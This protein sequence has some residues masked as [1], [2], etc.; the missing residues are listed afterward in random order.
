[1]A[2]LKS[3][4]QEA[5]A[6]HYVL[7]GNASEAYRKAYSTKT[8][9]SQ[10][11]NVNAATLLKNTNVAPRVNELQHKASEAADKSFG[12]DAEWMLGR[13]KSIDELDIADLLDDD[14]TPLPVKQWPKVWRTSISGLDINTLMTGDIET[15]VRKIKMPDK[16]KNLE[17]IGRH[18]EV[19][20]FKDKVEVSTGKS[21]GDLL[22]EVR[23]E[24]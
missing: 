3:P 14:G 9:S 15:I 17:L 23:S 12:I 4:K 19:Q 2:K 8:K 21:L 18:V 11:V 16:L 6:Q 24:R 1:M 22:A 7:T 10:T 13:L 20:A 5:F